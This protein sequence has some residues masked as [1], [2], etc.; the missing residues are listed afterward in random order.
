MRPRHFFMMWLGVTA[1]AFGL[2]L[3]LGWLLSLW[4]HPPISGLVTGLVIVI[5]GGYLV[6]SVYRDQMKQMKCLV[7]RLGAFKDVCYDEKGLYYDKPDKPYL[8][9]WDEIAGYNIPEVMAI[10]EYA[11]APPIFNLIRYFRWR[12]IDPE[13]AATGIMKVGTVQF[14]KKDGSSIIL[15]NVVFPYRLI[16]IFDKYIAESNQKK[17]P[18]M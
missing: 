11:R 6:Y 7:A 17:G 13:Y 5:G 10:S 15:Q 18:H 8:L 1:L 3:T 4:M 14:I 16:P 9:K 2:L 12:N